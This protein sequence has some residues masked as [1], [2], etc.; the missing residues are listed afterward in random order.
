MIV[1]QFSLLLLSF[2]APSSLVASTSF[3]TADSNI[4]GKF[5]RDTRASPSEQHVTLE[6][7][8]FLCAPHVS[9][10]CYANSD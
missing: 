10:H 5:D 8:G 7:I 6:I 4:R 1:Q 3:A 2:D 9:A